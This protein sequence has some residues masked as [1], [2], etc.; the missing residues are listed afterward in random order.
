MSKKAKRKIQRTLFKDLLIQSTWCKLITENYNK[1]ELNQN[2]EINSSNKI[3]PGNAKRRR[4]NNNNNVQF[5][6]ASSE[7]IDDEIV[8]LNPLNVI[9]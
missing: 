1:H 2:G 5:E 3:K 8:V 9:L 6:N 4:L 7:I